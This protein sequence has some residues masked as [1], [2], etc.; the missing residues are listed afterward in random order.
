R[1][2]CSP[3]RQGEQQQRTLMTAAK[4]LDAAMLAGLL[5]FT[6]AGADRVWPFFAFLMG[7]A[8]ALW[9]PAARALTPSL[10]PQEILPT[11]IAQRSI[12]FQLSVVAGPALGGLLFSVRAWLVYAVAVVL[13]L[14]ATG[15]VLAIRAGRE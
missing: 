12:G 13:S 10:V 5:A 11:A 7:V 6:L 3:H 8:S 1:C 9:A 15:C 14:A 4:A 2:C